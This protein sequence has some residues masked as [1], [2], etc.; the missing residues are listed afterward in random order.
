MTGAVFYKQSIH[1]TR[2]VRAKQFEPDATLNVRVLDA[3]WFLEWDSYYDFLPDRFAQTLK[4][5]VSRAIRSNRRWVAS[6]YYAFGINDYGRLS[7]VP[8]R[9]RG[10]RDVVS[11]QVQIEPLKSVATKSSRSSPFRGQYRR[12][13]APACAAIHST[14]NEPRKRYGG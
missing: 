1:T 10:R 3:T 2:G 7:Q 14:A 11:A 5:G 8:L 6:A 9:C 13:N 12:S 4:P